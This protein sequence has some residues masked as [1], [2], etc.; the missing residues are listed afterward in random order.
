MS[1]HNCR[2]CPPD[3]IF[4]LISSSTLYKMVL[5]L[6]YLSQSL[7]LLPHSI[8][9]IGQLHR[10]FSMSLDTK[11]ILVFIYITSCITGTLQILGWR[12]CEI[13]SINGIKTENQKYSFCHTYRTIC[14]IK[15]HKSI[16]SAKRHLN[17]QI[18]LTLSCV[19][20]YQYKMYTKMYSV[21]I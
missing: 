8:Q 19:G 2:K 17:S 10:Y 4:F 9:H 18:T 7:V 15:S 12:S 21:F 6:I 5:F 20:V 16:P 11:V 14:S 1:L 13:F 3:C